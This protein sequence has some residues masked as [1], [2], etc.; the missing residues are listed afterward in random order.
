MS[1]GTSNTM[2]TDLVDQKK[3]PWGPFRAIIGSVVSFFVAQEVASLLLS[4]YVQTRQWTELQT[5][6]WA[7]MASTKFLYYVLVECLTIGIILLFVRG[8]PIKV[9]CR[10]IGLVRP[11]VRDLGYLLLGFIGY[12]LIYFVI[13]SV[14]SLILPIDVNQRQDI[15]FNATQN[16]TSSLVLIFASLVILPPIVEEIV[17]R[18]FLFR[19]LR[20]S[21]HPVLAALVTSV[22]FAIPHSWQSTDGTT[23]WNAAVDTFSLSLVLCYLRERTG[24]LY[25]GMGV[26]A[27]KNCIAFLALFIFH[28][29]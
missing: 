27:I 4:A 15:G 11:R 28:V 8:I 20:R 13:L 2:N 26:H 5:S 17:F 22:L 25:A 10:A 23:L 3:V 14:S 12:Y 21:L 16:S 1:N 18:G 6:R 19:G 9:V 24:A 29:Q 7:D